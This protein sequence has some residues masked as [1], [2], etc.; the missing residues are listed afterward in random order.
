MTTVR[1][2]CGM[3]LHEMSGAF[4]GEEVEKA[5][6]G[7]SFSAA[8]A[9]AVKRRMDE[10]EAAR[11]AGD[12]TWW[13]LRE[14]T[15]LAVGTLDDFIV[16]TDRAL[17]ECGRHASFSAPAF[18]GLVLDRDL[19]PG[20]ENSIPPFLRGR[21]LWV[22]ARLAPGAHSAAATA[23]LG[24]ALQ[25]LDP[26]APAPLSVGACRALAQ[27]VP[28]APKDGLV[29]FLGPA[30]QGLG[31]LL[32]SEFNAGEASKAATSAG[33]AASLAN[34]GDC[35]TLRL[36]LEAMLVV[37]KSDA[38]AAAAWSGALAPAT[39]RVWAAKVADPLLAADARDVLEAL[40]AVPACVPSLH[41]LAVPTLSGVLASPDGQGPML[42]ESTL[43]LLAGLLK[44]AGVAEARAAHAACFR[45]VVALVV[46]SDDVGILQ[47]CAECLRA[48]LRS[49][50]VD[51]LAW[52]VDGVG[53]GGEVL[54]SYLDAVARLLSPSLE[55]GACVFAA[56]LLG[57]MLRRLRGEIA[58][59]LPEIVSA[60]VTR[61]ACAKQPNL[62]ASLM[63]IFARLVHS[64]CDALLGLLAQ[65]PVPPGGT[66][67]SGEDGVAPSRNALELVLRAWCGYQPD[68]SGAFD[69]KLTTSALATL[70][71]SGNPALEGVGV[72]GELVIETGETGQAAIRTRA[73]ARAT[74][75]DRYTTVPATAKVLELLADAVL[76]A[77]EAA[78]AGGG[79]G[80]EDEWES[81][82]DGDSDDDDDEGGGGGG[83]GG[84]FF[85]GD[86]FDRILAKGIDDAIDDDEDEAEDPIF[87]IDTQG[88]IKERLG[89]MHA[90]G[91]LTGVAQVLNARRQRAL[92]ALM[93]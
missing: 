64:D 22:A 74:G 59:L 19:A 77:Q 89:A 62:V 58:P 88:F 75:P 87:G 14:A 42:V 49:G 60:V 38:E 68:V 67:E 32:E 26:R 36:V 79:G 24:A 48:F 44:P 90:R 6:N 29:P 21:A 12:S 2:T 85:G 51:S 43:D 15:L 63:S 11:V 45:H 78:L 39:L 47:S 23:V 40:A 76:E 30:Y 3:L 37:V 7:G 57:Q 50:G 61:V 46:S 5:A 41:Q 69:I 56:P 86:L 4:G 84:S 1:A 71:A 81:D 70:L 18:L 83:G 82:G 55:D 72:K 17:S 52:G 80:E 13:K 93:Q 10:A 9:A 31:T 16:E 91:A 53:G 54:R 35:E 25:S 28:L 73:K 33:A 8:L 66:A 92:M 34:D 20:S 27:Y 65:M